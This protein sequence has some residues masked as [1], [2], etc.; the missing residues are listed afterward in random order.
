MKSIPLLLTSICLFSIQ[1]NKAIA[2]EWEPVT[3]HILT[4]WA[5]N[6]T[7]D[8]VWQV[9]PRPQLERTEWLNLN[10]L[11]D[12]AVAE[13]SKDTKPEKWEGKILVPFTIETQLSG[14][15]RELTE[16][17]AIWYQRTFEVPGNWKKKSLLLHFEAS[18][19]ETTVWLNGQL[20]GNH[21]GGYDPFTF[22]ISGAVTG[23]GEQELLVKVYDPQASVFKSLGKQTGRTRDYERCSGIWQTVWIEP[24][25]AKASIASIKINTSLKNVSL[26]T[27][28]R[29]KSSGL[30][31]KYEVF[32]GNSLV[33][34]STSDLNGV[35][36]IDITSPKLWS[37]DSPFLYDLKVS[38][39]KG[40][41]SIDMVK[42]YCGLRTISIADASDGKEILLNGEPIFQMGPLDQNYWPGGGLTPPSDDAVK[43]EAKYL[44]Q[45]GCNM[46][47]LHIKRNPARFYYHCDRAGLL[48]WQDFVSAQNRN[49][50][51]DPEDSEFWFNEQKLMVEGLYNHPSIV[52]WIIYNEGWGQHDSERIYNLSKPLDASRL[53]SIGSGWVDYPGI[54]DIRDVHEYTYRPAVPVPGTHNRAIVLG[55]C[56]GF[57]S[58]LPEN[59]WTGRSN[60][61][62]EPVNLISG[63]GHPTVPRDENIK[64]DI[65]RPTFT[66]G[67]NFEKQYSR[68]VDQLHLL[69]NS[70]LRGAVYTQMTDMKLE[71]NGYLTFDRKVSKVDPERLGEIHKRLYTDPPEQ[72]IIL[73]SSA[74]TPQTWQAAEIPLPNVEKEEGVLDITLVQ[75][76]P[77]FDSLEWKEVSGPF[78]NSL[79]TESGT[80][81]DGESQLIIRKSITLE[82][83]PEKASVR[84]YYTRFE[85]PRMTMMHSRIYING[86]FVA[87]ETTRQI[88]SEHRM[89]EVILPP[90]AL[91]NLREGENILTVRFVQG[92]SWYSGNIEPGPVKFE[93][94]IAM[95]KF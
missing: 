11:W 2:Q 18:D 13:M 86:E 42:S 59:N 32:D 4:V 35:T 14:I 16:E 46:V 94:D 89:A 79:E 8:N 50:N 17:E 27:S 20:M 53:F 24:V 33:A 66:Y 39:L 37:P 63:G 74:D 76:E 36:S 56:G 55:E 21:R 47:R 25:P 83:V 69:Q 85:G 44:R 81:W 90:E 49:T 1:I 84:V 15:A 65:F 95:T 62:G 23:S 82:T 6:V 40:K 41:K 51:P 3:D 29:G 92:L 43:F 10:G 78:G 38:L 19:F 64:H 12:Y 22:D 60:M 68:F 73:E 80:H 28:V 70:G 31:I 45:I 67:E 30:K 26:E 54:G 88:M 71:E 72:T 48:V 52:M 34:S 77:E 61:T 57:A 87:D 75:K 9:Y 5:E 58:G 7:P 91:A 93:V